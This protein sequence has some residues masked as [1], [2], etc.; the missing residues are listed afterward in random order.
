MYVNLIKAL[1]II[2]V[3]VFYLSSCLVNQR[4]LCWALQL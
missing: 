2:S 4:N 1:L 3:G